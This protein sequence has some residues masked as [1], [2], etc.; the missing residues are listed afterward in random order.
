MDIERRRVEFNLIDFLREIIGG[1][2]SFATKSALLEI[3][4]LARG[5]VEVLVG[6]WEV[7]V[8]GDVGLTVLATGQSATS[9]TVKEDPLSHS[10]QY[11]VPENR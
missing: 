9:S 8:V 7:A 2:A 4:F 10:A 5:N 11:S 6:I 3:T 1:S